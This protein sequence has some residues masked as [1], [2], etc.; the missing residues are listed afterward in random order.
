MNCSVCGAVLSAD[1]RALG[2][3][4]GLGD[5][6]LPCFSR[7]LDVPVSRLLEKIEEFRRAGCLLFSA[8]E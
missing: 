2:K 4:F 6:C 7:K 1:E 8:K 3:K 5:F